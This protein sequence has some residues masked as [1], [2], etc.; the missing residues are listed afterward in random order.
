MPNLFENHWGNSRQ[1]HGFWEDFQNG[2]VTGDLWTTV[3]GDTGAA[4]AN[5]D[6]VGGQLDLVTGT[7]DNNE[8]YLHTTKEQFLIADNKPCE[9]IARFAF[10][11]GATN[12]SNVIFGFQ[13]AGGVNALLDNG[14]GPAASYTGA[15]FFKEDGQLEWSVETSLGTLQQTT[16]LTT[17]NSLDKLSKAAAA[18]AAV[19]HVLRIEINAVSSTKAVADFF[20]TQ[21]NTGEVA[22]VHVFSQEFVYTSATEMD[23]IIGIK[24]GSST[25]EIMTPDYVGARQLR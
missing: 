23:V 22:E 5:L 9:V 18:G 15:V 11:E 10:A 24:A 19:F 4:P 1:Q 6:A 20:I 13:S 12:V 21:G 3:Q 25:T 2:I 14:A 16:R 17:V 8:C 7:V